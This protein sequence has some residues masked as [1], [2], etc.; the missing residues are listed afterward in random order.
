MGR[1]EKIE[2][3]GKRGEGESAATEEQDDAMREKKEPKV[4]WPLTIILLVLVTVVS[5]PSSCPICK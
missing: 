2:D 3:N 1:G 5:L 4:S